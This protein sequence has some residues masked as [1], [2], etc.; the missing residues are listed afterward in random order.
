MDLKQTWKYSHYSQV[1]QIL[2]G[3]SKVSGVISAFNVNIDAIL[4]INGARILELINEHSVGL[5]S[6]LQDEPRQIDSF[7]DLLRGIV[8]CFSKGIAE[9]WLISNDSTYKIISEALGYDRLQMGG[10]AGIVANAAAVSNVRNVYVH[11][12]SLPGDQASLFLDLDNLKSF[13]TNGSLVKAN[14]IN[15]PDLPLIHWI[16]EFNK[17]DSF[18]FEGETFTCPKSNRFIATYDPLNLA[19]TIDPSFAAVVDH[20]YSLVILSGYHML[21]HSLPG[22]VTSEERITSSIPVITSWK[23]TGVI[24]H[25]ELASTQDVV[26]RKEILD[27]V[28]PHVDSAGL[29]ERE[30]IDCLEVMGEQ[31]LADVIDSDTSSVN[32]FKGLLTLVKMLNLPRVQLHMFG[33]YITV[34][35][36]GFSI[37]P[38]DNL[39]GMLLASVAAA[40]KCGSGAIDTFE[41][42]IWALD[43]GLNEPADHS[44]MEFERLFNYLEEEHG[45]G[46][47]FLESGIG[48]IGEHDVI[49]VPTILVPKPKTLVGMGDSISSLSLIG[50]L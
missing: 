45:V 49:A 15:R 44:L 2:K 10:Q 12:A 34:Q 28:V 41:S 27:I 21:T 16:I 50:A 31:E 30:L 25:L 33:L 18:E 38:E 4:P 26:V 7:S 47:E 17:G 1:P 29:N 6:L 32:V 43:Q 20:P 39:R 5:E 11:C 24:T 9:E 46:K 22:G 36:P 37:S 8:R 42:L 14:K 48:S 3:T 23:K 13:D 35:H 19:L 40:S